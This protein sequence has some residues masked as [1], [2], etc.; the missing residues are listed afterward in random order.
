MAYTLSYKAPSSARSDSGNYYRFVWEDKEE[1]DSC[2]PLHYLWAT[3]PCSQ[4]LHGEDFGGI[5]KA[6]AVYNHIWHIEVP[7][8]LEIDYI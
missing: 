5:S 2:G 8:Q 3:V 1:A 4:S 6:D 7:I